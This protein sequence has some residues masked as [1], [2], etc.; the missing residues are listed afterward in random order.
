[1]SFSFHDT[2]GTDS[3]PADEKKMERKEEFDDL[4]ELRKNFA[5]KIDLLESMLLFLYSLSCMLMDA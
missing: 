5:V 2:I 3:E 4:E 1:M